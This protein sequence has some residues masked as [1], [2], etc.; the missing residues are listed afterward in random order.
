MVQIHAVHVNV[1]LSLSHHSKIR[2][3]R[4]PIRLTLAVLCHL[5]KYHIVIQGCVSWCCNI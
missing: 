3:K 1:T 5:K 4:E 2:V